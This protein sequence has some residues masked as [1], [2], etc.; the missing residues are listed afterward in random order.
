MSWYTAGVI[1]LEEKREVFFTRWCDK[2][3][4]THKLAVMSPA[5]CD[6]TDWLDL[7]EFLSKSF[8]WACYSELEFLNIIN[9]DNIMWCEENPNKILVVY[10]GK[11][12]NLEIKYTTSLKIRLFE[13]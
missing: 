7:K 8:S 13:V 5:I 4:Y 6:E 2:E 10:S 9:D 3:T 12:Y 1:P 11:V